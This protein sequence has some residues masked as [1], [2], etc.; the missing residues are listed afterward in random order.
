[1]RTVTYDPALLDILTCVTIGIGPTDLVLWIAVYIPFRGGKQEGEGLKVKLRA[2]YFKCRV[3]K[4]DSGEE[5]ADSKRKFDGIS[6]RWDILIPD[7]VARSALNRS[8]LGVIMTG[9]LNQ[10]YDHRDES[11]RS[12]RVRTE[13][14]GLYTNLAE[15]FKHLQSKY[16]TWGMMRDDLVGPYMIDHVFTLLPDQALRAGGSPKG[17]Q[18]LEVSDHVGVFTSRRCKERRAGGERNISLNRLPL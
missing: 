12:P 10:R 13:A 14:T 8:H 16:S 17:E 9:D 18:W 7:R 6:W 15:R 4:M 11:C 1:V 2:W 5:K 3:P